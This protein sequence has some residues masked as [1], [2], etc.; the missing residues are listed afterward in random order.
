M[1][2]CPAWAAWLLPLIVIGALAAAA[3]LALRRA[4]HG[5][6]I[7]AAALS[8]I[9][10]ASAPAAWSLTP[11]MLG[12]DLGLPYAG[13]DLGARPRRDGQLPDVAKLAD[14]LIA[15]RGQA[16]FLA[17]TVDAN[18]AAPLIL[19]T[20]EPVMAMGGFSGGDPILTADELKAMVRVGQVRFFL[21]SGSGGGP[22]PNQGS[23]LTRW[24]SGHCAA[25]PEAE[26]RGAQ[27]N[28]P[29]AGSAQLFDC[30]PMGG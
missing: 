1:S 6:Q 16:E 10:L 15:N 4:A 23:D 19:A 12:G 2:A 8:L 25:V 7:A 22:R 13:P 18:T 27:T 28:G 3:L 9:G 29:G 26:W 17:A 24:V 30:G 5:W 21:I 14:F 20:G 11:V